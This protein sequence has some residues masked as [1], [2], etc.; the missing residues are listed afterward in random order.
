MYY[1]LPV[2]TGELPPCGHFMKKDD[3]GY[4][5]KWNSVEEYTDKILHLLGHPKELAE[6][7]A[8]GHNLVVEKYNWEKEEEKLREVYNKMFKI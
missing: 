3:F 4:M 2:L 1:S 7:G 6:F 8:T 5:V